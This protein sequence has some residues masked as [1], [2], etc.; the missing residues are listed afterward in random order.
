ML[1]VCKGLEALVGFDAHLLS[2]FG[3]MIFSLLWC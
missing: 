3:E 1:C 2:L